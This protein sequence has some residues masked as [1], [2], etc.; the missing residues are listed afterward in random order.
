MKAITWKE[1][2]PPEVLHLEDIEE[3]IPADDEVRIRVQAVNI[4]PGDCEMR[5]F[6]THPSMWVPLRLFVGIRRPR[7]RF[8]V[9]GQEMSGVVESVG[10]E[11]TKFKPGDEVFGLTQLR[12]G[13]YAEYRGSL[14]SKLGSRLSVRV[15]R[16]TVTLFGRL[17][18]KPQGFWGRA[19]RIMCV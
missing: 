17:L 18:I 1:Y 5:R 3:P 6:Q 7:P 15:I 12:W 16:G 11:V 4:F 8:H 2:G 19:E 9:L 13:A 14:A 10:K